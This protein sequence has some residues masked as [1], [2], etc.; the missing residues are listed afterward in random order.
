MKERRLAAYGLVAAALVAALTA[1]GLFVPETAASSHAAPP[2]APTPPPAPR[3]TVS[4]PRKGYDVVIRGGRVMDPET[5]YD[6]V[7]NV[8]LRKGVIRAITPDPLIGKRTIKARGLVVAPGF[9]DPLSYG[10]N[11]F[12][13]WYKVADGVTTIYGG[14]GLDYTPTA[15]FGAMKSRRPP[16][17]YGGV[18][19]EPRERTKL[20]LTPYGKPTRAQIRKLADVAGRQIRGGWGGV[21]FEPEYQPGTTLNEMVAV[22]KV[23]AK[24]KVPV[25]FHVRYSDDQPPGTNREALEEVL[26]V[27]RRTGASVHVEHINSTGGT[28]TMEESLRQLERARAE[29][30]D[31]TADVYPYDF[32]ST[33]LA[34]ARFDGDWRKRFRITYRDLMIP[35]TG[36]R[37]TASTYREYKRENAVVA[38]FA[39]P[40][41]DVI[42]ALKS[43]LVMIG[44]DGMLQAEEGR[45]P[46]AAG[47]FSRV[48]GVYVREKNVLTLMEALA[49]MTIM[50]ARRFERSVPGFR[51]KGRLQVGMDADI[52]IFDPNIVKDRATVK[53][54]RQESAGIEWVLINGEIVKTPERLRRGTRPGRP[55]KSDPYSDPPGPPPSPA[56][57]A[58]PYVWPALGTPQPSPSARSNAA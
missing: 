41:R 12:G 3:P 23:A 17:N 37:L 44:S 46:R 5:G 38:A 20:R 58:T 25:L 8:G 53:N 11:G 30:I 36:E 6:G 15:F 55:I 14:H 32:W 47:T 50:P 4:F 2:G 45:H 18:V 49:K 57:G 31:V 9:I 33:F 29:G 39:I 24:Y 28:F 27:A 10:P 40:E 48:L 42:A 7:A 54:P 34:S 56:P 52:T 35:D 26:E 16:L 13:E 21:D 51:K 19:D 43:P 22:A 1:D